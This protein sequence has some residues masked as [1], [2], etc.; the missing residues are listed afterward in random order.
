VG[1]GGL[2]HPARN[3]RKGCCDMNHGAFGLT[4][5]GELLTKMK[6]DYEKLK[7][8]PFDPYLAFNFFVTA[9]CMLDWLKPGKSNQLIRENLRN[10]EILLQITS[11]IASGAKHFSNLS[12]HHVSVSDM[13]PSA[14]YFVGYFPKEAFPIG[15]FSQGSLVIHLAGDAEKAFGSTINAVQLAE[16]VLNYWNAPGKV[17]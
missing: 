4:T 6:H 7:A 17:P 10:S 9:E 11:H 1:G 14:G 2:N 15:Y 13:T 8:A 5:P 12:S 3:S 16:K